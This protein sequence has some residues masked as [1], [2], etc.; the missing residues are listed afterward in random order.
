MPIGGA[1]YLVQFNW[2]YGIV[3]ALGAYAGLILIWPAKESLVPCMVESCE[4]AEEEQA[5]FEKERVVTT[6]TAEKD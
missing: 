4:H 2:Y 6:T 5:G 1:I 3:V